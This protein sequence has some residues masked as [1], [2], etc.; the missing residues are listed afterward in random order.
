M[1]LFRKEYG[2]FLKK[3]YP[4]ITFKKSNKIKFEFEGLFENSSHIDQVYFKIPDVF[5]N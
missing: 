5:N 2:Q 1:E 3:Q 4:E